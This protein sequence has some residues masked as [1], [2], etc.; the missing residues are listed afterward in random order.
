MALVPLQHH[1]VTPTG[2]P[3]LEAQPY[4]KSSGTRVAKAPHLVLTMPQPTLC[5]WAH[6]KQP[7]L[8][9]VVPR[10]TAEQSPREAWATT[11]RRRL[12]GGSVAE[13][14]NRLWPHEGLLQ[15]RFQ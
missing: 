5:W 2:G 9:Y 14:N 12:L 15:Q 8:M 11:L 1:G 6:A 13:G 3:A 4:G 7:P 10:T